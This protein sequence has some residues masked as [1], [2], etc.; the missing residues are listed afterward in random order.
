MNLVQQRRQLLHLVDDHGVAA[1]RVDLL[2]GTPK[3]VDAAKR[4]GIRQTLLAY[5]SLAL[6]S[7]EV[8]P[9]EMTSAYAA[10]A[11]GGLVY[12]PRLVERIRSFDGQTLEQN[13]PEA[14]EATTPQAAYVLLGM[15]RGVTQR[16]TGAAA[17]RLRLNLAGKTGTT[18]DYTDAWFV[19]M[20]PRYT[21]GVWVGRPNGAPVPGL[22][23]RLAAA[24]I[25]FE[26]FARSGQ[27]PIALPPALR[28]AVLAAV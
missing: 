5:P 15:L 25:L 28:R 8:T 22:I 7:F 1:V 19:G 10:F 21:I 6:G 18:N 26:A 17:A 20:T 24:P 9:M 14:A 2:V 4:L 27:A 16:G 3:V 13:L 11:N 23:G 12:K